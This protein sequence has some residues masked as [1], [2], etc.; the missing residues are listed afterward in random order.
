MALRKIKVKSRKG[1]LLTLLVLVLFVLILGEVLTYVVINSDFNTISS[2]FA[3]SS[4][5]SATVTL[6]STSL[7]SSLSQNLQ[8]SLKALALYEGNSSLRKYNFITNTSASL[9]SLMTNETVFGTNMNRFVGNTS[10]RNLLY[11]VTVQLKKQGISVTFTNSTLNV[12]QTEPFLVNATYTGVAQGNASFGS[13]SIPISITTGA[14]LNGTTDVLSVEQGNPAQI[15][16]FGQ[17]PIAKMVGN[18]HTT[19]LHA[20]YGSSS[21]YMFAYGTVVVQPGSP[22]CASIPAQYENGNYILATQSSVNIPSN[23]C[24]MGGLILSSWSNANT[25]ATP[26]APY[27]YYPLLGKDG[28]LD[29]LTNGTQVLL[30]GNGLDVLNI[31]ELKDAIQNNYY[32][33]SAYVPSYLQRSQQSFTSRSQ[34]GIFSFNLENRKAVSFQP[35][36]VQSLVVPNPGVFS[37][38]KITATAWFN[39]PSALGSAATARLVGKIGEWNMSICGSGLVPC[40]V[41]P[42]AV[43]HYSSLNLLPNTWYFAAATINGSSSTET[44]YIDGSKVFSGPES[45]VPTTSNVAFGGGDF[46]GTLTNVQIYGTVLAPAQINKIYSTGISAAPLDNSTLLGWWPLSTNF[47][48]YGGNSDNASIYSVGG[49]SIH[50]TN[51]MNYYGDPITSGAS[52]TQNTSEITGVLNCHGLNT[53]CIDPAQQHFFL[54]STGL[55]ANLSNTLSEA[56]ALGL[57]NAVIPNQ[58]FFNG[59]GFMNET[60]PFNW[61]SSS[62][63]PYSISLWMDPAAQN[64]NPESVVVQYKLPSSIATVLL[65]Q[66]GGLFLGGTTNGGV[67]PTAGG[68]TPGKWSNIVITYSGSTSTLYINGTQSYSTSGSAIFPVSGSYLPLGLSSGLCGSDVVSVLPYQGGIADYRL[69]NVALTAAQVKQLYVNDT[70]TGVSA[71]GIWQLGSPNDGMFNQ[72]PEELIGNTGVF[73]NSNAKPC[74][75]ANT[76][77]GDCAEQIVPIG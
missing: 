75:N 46:A 66:D 69:Y 32:Y 2:S 26:L 6:I 15:S 70:V 54:G 72:T 48:D 1:V 51:L 9:K 67:C 11:T 64:T 24:G 49:S 62:S 33:A 10:L 61:L 43:T 58:L 59:T 68:V 60:Q 25:L 50:I 5:Q 74:S 57:G 45:V 27:L 34:A 12:Y 4:A 41:D 36:A 63:Q 20:T 56:Q 38:T 73:Y 42:S 17:L 31:S 30:D 47:N 40:Y 52:A 39:M 18:S 7:Q 14:P 55:A 19:T 53:D 35:L 71:N 44:L 23:I 28:I 8:T 22:T 37:S 77:I 76:L 16:T 21:P 3:T 13:F 65:Y 29:N